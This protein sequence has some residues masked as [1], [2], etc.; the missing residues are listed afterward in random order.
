MCGL[1]AS[2]L[3]QVSIPNVYGVFPRCAY[4]PLFDPERAI[5]DV[6]GENPPPPIVLEIRLGPTLRALL[7]GEAPPGENEA[8]LEEG[9]PDFLLEGWGTA[10]SRRSFALKRRRRSAR[11]DYAR[12]C[13][14]SGATF[15]R[16]PSGRRC[17]SRA[18]PAL[19]IAVAQQ[20]P[21]LRLRRAAPSRRPERR[22]RRRKSTAR[23][24]EVRVTCAT[25][26][27]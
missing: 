18:E 26:R 11:C 19:A 27:S 13:F 1:S 23:L 16:R 17:C 10:T 21:A 15:K 25:P 20:G 9:V 4:C 14:G 12:C 6:L 22:A 7:R 24:E 8:E 5:R 3:R 2:F